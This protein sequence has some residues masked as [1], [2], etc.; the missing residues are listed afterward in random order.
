MRSVAFSLA[1]TV[2][3]VYTFSSSCGNWYGRG[4][5]C[6]S[7]DRVPGFDVPALALGE[8]RPNGSV[9]ELGCGFGYLLKDA[10]AA[11]PDLRYGC[12]N[13]KEPSGLKSLG[14]MPMQKSEGN[15]SFTMGEFKSLPFGNQS[16]DLIF[17]NALDKAMG[18][19]GLPDTPH[20]IEWDKTR[21]LLQALS[22]VWRV[23]APG[24]VAL[25]MFGN[26][27]HSLS[28]QDFMHHLPSPGPLRAF[29]AHKRQ[30]RGVWWHEMNGGACATAMG[31]F[32]ILSRRPHPH[33]TLR[34]IEVSRNRSTS[35][36][37]HA[38]DS[39]YLRMLT[40]ACTL[41]LSHVEADGEG[42]GPRPLRA[43]GARGPF[44]PKVRSARK[45]ERILN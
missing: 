11:R 13:R 2:S 4:I 12:L 1:W 22:E 6:F 3:E 10:H 14:C 30:E 16:V 18:P 26:R 31:F 40:H 9:L 24:G 17:S 44:G 43:E 41:E 7:R 32:V 39:T 45:L 34:M 25:L 21:P 28:G 42:G 23:L 35:T 19:A 27:S 8:M 33:W 36:G 37:G 15:I 20:G 5:G 38:P 29:I